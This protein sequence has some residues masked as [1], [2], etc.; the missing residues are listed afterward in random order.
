MFGK[1]V[2]DYDLSNDNYYFISKRKC[3]HKEET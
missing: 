3:S 1:K 2:I